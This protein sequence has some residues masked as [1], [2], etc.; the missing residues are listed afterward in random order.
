MFW[1]AGRFSRS[2]SHCLIV[3]RRFIALSTSWCSEA[4][5]GAMQDQTATGTSLLFLQMTL[6]S[7]FW[8]RLWPGK[9]RR[10]PAFTPICNAAI[11]QSLWR[12]E[13]WQI[14]RHEKWPDMPSVSDPKALHIASHLR[15]AAEDA[16]D[17]LL[18]VK[19]R[20]AAYHAQQATE[21]LLL[22]LLTSEDIH[23]QRHES[24]QL[25]IMAGKLPP[26]H[27]MLDGLRRLEFL[28]AFATTYR[29]PKTGGRLPAPPDWGK[30]GDA[31]DQIDR[32]IS[33]A[34][35]HFSVDVSADPK[36]P[37][38]NPTPMRVSNG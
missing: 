34:C 12:I 35:D 38:R 9:P 1:D 6:L 5:H 17:A 2:C 8:T 24:H 37:A 13:T 15:L 33:R 4:A 29:Y 27:P 32:L 16:K 20:N 31:L 7:L 11:D 18:A 22:A 28:T 19:S 23:I 3:S 36:L 21:K 26:D 25:G 10:L 30:I 14:R